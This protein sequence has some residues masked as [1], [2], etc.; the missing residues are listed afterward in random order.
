MIRFIAK[1]AVAAAAAGIM[2]AGMAAPA[3]AAET[4]APVVEGS[5]EYDPQDFGGVNFLSN[6]CIGNWSGD[7]IS[8]LNVAKSD[9]TDLCNGWDQNP[10]GVNVASNICALNWDWSNAGSL[11][12]LGTSDVDKVCNWAK[13]QKPANS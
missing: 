1:T 11:G 3:I 13:H 4:T 5:Y 9:V 10:N 2:A 8:L 6:L 12:L 7:V